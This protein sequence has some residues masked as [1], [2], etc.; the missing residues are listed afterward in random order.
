MVSG[1]GDV[2][3]L[4]G[5]RVLVGVGGPDV[6]VGCGISVLVGLSVL[7]GFG[8]DVLGGMDVFVGCGSGVAV[9][10]SLWQS[11]S[12]LSIR[13]SPSS[14]MALKQSSLAP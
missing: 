4:V 2:G 9:R 14:S 11:E 7:V 13:W 3:V 1:G 5:L 12:A 10:S 6:L 8:V